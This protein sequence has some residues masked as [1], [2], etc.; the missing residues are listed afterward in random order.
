LSRHAGGD[1]RGQAQHRPRLLHFPR[2][3]DWPAFVDVLKKAQDR[4]VEIRVLVD[5]VGGGYLRSPIA[6]RLAAAGIR[7]VRFMHYWQPWRMT[8]VNMRNHKKLLIID[9]AVGFTGGLNI[10][11]Q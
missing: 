11:D 6:E 9:G 2:R 8:F 1:R 4:G 3:Q 5:G 10:A 7:T